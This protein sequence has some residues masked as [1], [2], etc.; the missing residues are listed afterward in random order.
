MKNLKTNLLTLIYNHFS[1]DELQTLC[2]D[3]G[4]R[5]E[6][7]PL[8]LSLEGQARELI[9][10]FSR[11]NRLTD[12]VE[13]CRE[14]RTRLDW[15]DPKITNVEQLLGKQ[16]EPIKAFEPEMVLVPAGS[17]IMG[18]PG[19]DD[20]PKHEKLQHTFYLPDYRIGRFPITNEEYSAFLQSAKRPSPRGW[21]D[22]VAPRGKER[23][24]VVNI[25]WFEARSYCRWLAAET[26]RPYRLPS[27]AEW[28][29]AARGADSFQYPW[30][31]EWRDGLC[32]H[33]GQETTAVDAF[34]QGASPFGC[35][36]MIGN[37]REWTNTLWGND[38]ITPNYSYPYQANDGREEENEDTTSYR[39]VRS[40]TYRDRLGR[41]RCSA[42]AWYS[43]NNKNR[44]RGFRIVMAHPF[45]G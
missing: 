39:I 45:K 7:L 33:H 8:G 28:E 44:R 10:L 14:K 37:V 2:F 16:E 22:A 20:F 5:Y 40:S 30:G 23:H 17:F 42:R 27:E 21:L 32:N 19:A 15:P 6:D 12:L 31:N 9:L 1:R 13:Y 38:Y 26:G 25:S 24:P 43:P 35:E 3:L 29:K 34:K 18:S 41:H 4:V 36:D 11:L